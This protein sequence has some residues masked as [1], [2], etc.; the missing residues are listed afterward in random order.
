M[1]AVDDGKKSTIKVDSR[2]WRK[3]L[4]GPPKKLL[5]PL[6]VARRVALYELYV[7]QELVDTQETHREDV[8]NHLSSLRN[9]SRTKKRIAPSN[10]SKNL[11]MS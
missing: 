11:L 3:K 6:Q 5:T 10:Q 2:P 9:L 4:T 1:A 8:Q 7:A